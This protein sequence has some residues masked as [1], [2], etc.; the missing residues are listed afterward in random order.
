MG[1]LT[2]LA[3]RRWLR[4]LL[5]GMAALN[6]VL[7]SGVLAIRATD[8]AEPFTT[9][10]ALEAFRA[11]ATSTTLAPP[12]PMPATPAADESAS[13]TIAPD[14]PLPDAVGATTTEPV[15]PDPTTT[16]APP[17]AGVDAPP[18][19]QAEAAPAEAAPTTTAPPSRAATPPTGV[20]VYDTEGYEQVD[21]FGGAR[22]DYPAESTITV[23]DADCGYEAAWRPL[24][25]REEIQMACPR[26][27]AHQMMWVESTNTFFDMSQT[28]RMTCDDD[29]IAFRVDPE[30]GATETFTCTDGDTT[31][32]QTVE[33]LDRGTYDVGGVA[34]D[35]VQV[36]VR[37]SATGGSEAQG[38]QQG[39]FRASDG[40]TLSLQASIDGSA[41]GP[42][43]DVN[44]E[45]RYTLEL[46]S[47]DP[48]R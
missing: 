44:Y 37:F 25:G 23:R 42:A 28:M 18:A 38:E 13:T 27:D 39:W 9:D 46:Q 19:A 45:E 29:A 15:A 7:A 30:I 35:A 2:G 1:N 14:V 17:A 22:H 36:R 41:P 16:T 26:V 20:Y 48:L 43:G 34:V 8:S 33:Y 31:S 11:G 21:A 4:R 24:E 5:Y 32:E 47:L 3:D 12:A 40:L 10:A 6:V